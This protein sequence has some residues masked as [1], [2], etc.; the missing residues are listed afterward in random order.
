M[1]VKHLQSKSRPFFRALRVPRR[2]TRPI[3]VLR[4]GS[5]TFH[6]LHVAVVGCRFGARTGQG[7]QVD[8]LDRHQKRKGSLKNVATF[9]F[10]KSMVFLGLLGLKYRFLIFFENA[11]FTLNYA[12]PQTHSPGD[13]STQHAE[14][15]S[16]DLRQMKQ[17]HQNI[18]MTL[19][20]AL[21]VT[22]TY[23][24]R[25]KLIKN[26]SIYLENDMYVWQYPISWIIS[27]LTK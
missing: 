2:V 11:T 23:K 4:L 25:Q 27:N 21:L 8:G 10:K 20:S 3:S 24:N 17:P 22:K 9:L 6:L 15:K 5:V 26:M 19:H 13:R 16:N 14:A 12:P 1:K 7:G 18:G